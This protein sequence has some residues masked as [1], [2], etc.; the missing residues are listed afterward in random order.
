MLSFFFRAE[1]FFNFLLYCRHT[2][3]AKLE[4]TNYDGGGGNERDHLL[5][6]LHTHPHSPTGPVPKC[7]LYENQ[8][9]T[10]ILAGLYISDS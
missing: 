10:K 7:F 3:F 9:C 6:A 5:P 8:L 2:Y 4:L 1:A